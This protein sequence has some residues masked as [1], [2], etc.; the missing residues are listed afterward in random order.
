MLTAYAKLLQQL[1]CI[2]EKCREI[3]GKALANVRL[4]RNP[5]AEV[6]D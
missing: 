3:A 1:L 2:W 5:Y 4:N 6:V